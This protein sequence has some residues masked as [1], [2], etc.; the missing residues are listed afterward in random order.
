[1]S[2]QKFFASRV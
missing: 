2:V 1:M